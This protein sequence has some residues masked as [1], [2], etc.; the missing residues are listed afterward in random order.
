MVDGIADIGFALSVL[1]KVRPSMPGIRR[2]T[3]KMSG[4]DR[5]TRSSASVP[6][7]G[8]SDDANISCKMDQ[9]FQSL[10][11]KGVVFNEAD[12]NH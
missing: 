6:I 4:F 5:S 10:A 12:S 3:S 7:L 8:Q 2:S 9:T 1:R 11:H